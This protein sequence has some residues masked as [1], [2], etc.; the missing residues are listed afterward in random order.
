M[1]I[2]AIIGFAVCGIFVSAEYFAYLYFLLALSVGLVKIV[3][4]RAMA[5]SAARPQIKVRLTSRTPAAEADLGS[6]RNTVEASIHGA[7]PRR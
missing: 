1:L 2:A 3:R 4:M 5:F 7:A 6:V